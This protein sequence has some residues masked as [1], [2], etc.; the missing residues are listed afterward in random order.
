LQY[1]SYY[2]SKLPVFLLLLFAIGISSCCKKRLY[3]KGGELKIAFVGFS[4]GDI[5]SI[6]LKRYTIEGQYAKA[7]DSAQLTLASDIPV[8]S[9]KKDTIW[10]SSYSTTGAIKAITLGSEWD[11]ILK[12]TNEHFRINSI[13]DE[14]HY[15]QIGKCSGKE[16][17][18]VNG[19][20]HFSINNGWHEG[21]TYYLQR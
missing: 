2:M 9:N 1:S 18:C 14:G 16:T 3:C 5:R 20:T 7:L 12:V 8:V 13:G 21:D 19:V 11:L 17:E 4:R 15:Y 10:L 6:T